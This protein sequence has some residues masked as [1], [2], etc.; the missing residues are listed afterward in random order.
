MSPAT[1]IILLAL[2]L[3][4]AMAIRTYARKLRSGCCGGG[5]PAPKAGA[6][7]VDRNAAHYPYRAELTVDGLTCPACEQRVERALGRLGGVWASVHGPE[8]NQASGG[9][10]VAGTMRTVTVRMKTPLTEAALRGAVQDAGYAVLQC[11]MLQP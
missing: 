2:I 8:K 3:L 1:V 6:P 11:R 9:S 4:C 5:D 7:R 10:A